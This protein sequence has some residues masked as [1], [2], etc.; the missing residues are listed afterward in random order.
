MA[1]GPT[2]G[3][4]KKSAPDMVPPMGEPRGA[5]AAAPRKAPA[6]KVATK[7]SGVRIPPS[8][9]VEVEYLIPYAN[10]ARTHSEDQIKQI[11][12]SIQKFGWT[13]PVLTDGKDGIIA[14]HGRVMA[15]RLLG[16]THVPIIELKAMSDADKR[17]YILADNKLAERAGWDSE[18]LA[19]ELGRL[20]GEDGFDLSLLGFTGDELSKIFGE[21]SSPADFPSFDNDIETEH[22]CPKCGYK[23]SGGD[24]AA[25]EADKA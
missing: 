15:A 18:L 3:R 13:V 5:G 14:G 1:S 6:G 19:M 21:A 2:P 11:A 23:F 22:T 9:I 25:R 20:K 4:T 24:K 12:A 10:N 8:R 17:A 7:G 16:L